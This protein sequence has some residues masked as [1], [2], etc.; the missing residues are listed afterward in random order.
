MSDAFF[1]GYGSLVNRKTHVYDNAHPARLTGWRRVWRHTALRPVAFL[2]A[3]PDAGCAID[4]LIAGVPGNDWAALDAREFAY[5]RVGLDPD[6]ADR[7]DHPL[8]AQPEMAIYT[9][10]KG[11][12]QP[13]T[14]DHPILLSYLDVV[15]QGYLEVFGEAG[16]QAFF[17]TTDGWTAP[18]LDDRADPFYPRHQTLIPAERD[19]VDHMLDQQG[20][21]LFR[22]TARE[23]AD[24]AAQLQ[25][26]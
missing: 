9:I 10:P 15:V 2:T 23:R 22:Q 4:G 25:I 7:V 11:K 24:Y 5:D 18:I 13:P 16:V 20:A 21:R 19:L 3:V 12:H 14:T 6:G 26:P 1:F 8:A 17:A